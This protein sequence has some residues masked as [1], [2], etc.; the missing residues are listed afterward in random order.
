MSYRMVYELSHLDGKKNLSI[1]CLRWD[2]Y[3][4]NAKKN[5][6]CCNHTVT[7]GGYPHAHFPGIRNMRMRIFPGIGRFAPLFMR[8][9]INPKILFFQPYLVGKKNSIFFWLKILK[10]IFTN[11]TKKISNFFSNQIHKMLHKM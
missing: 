9:R 6:L 3:Q 4:K 8:M 7:I 11:F 1:F 2:L 5:N 10:H